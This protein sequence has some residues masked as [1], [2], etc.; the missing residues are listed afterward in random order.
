MIAHITKHELRR[1]LRDGRS[2][3]LLLA[4]FVALVASLVLSLRDYQL[5]SLQYDQNLEQARVNWEQQSEKDPHDAAHDGTYVIKPLHPLAIIDKG[6]QPFSG[7]VVHL[8][9]HE[10]KQST[11]N[12]AKDQ[13]GVFRFGELTPGFMLTYVIPLLLIFLGFNAFTEENEKQTLRLLLVQGATRRDLALG[14]WLALFV[15][16]LV[17]WLLLFTVTLVVTFSFGDQVRLSLLEIMSLSGSYLLYFVIFINLIIWVS[18]KASSSGSS[19]TSLIA[20]WIVFTLIVPKVVTNLAGS[21]YPFPTLQTF[22][23]NISRDQESGLNGHNF[24]NDAAQDFEKKVLAEYGV[25]SI[26]ELPIEYG[27]LLLAEGEKYESEVYTKHFDLLQSQYTKQ[28]SIYRWSSFLSPMLAIRFVS[29]GIS[30]TDYGFQWHFED[31]AEKYR[32][33]FNTDLNMDIAEN[34]KGVDRYTAGNDL[35]VNIQEFNYEW[36]QGNE[37]LKSHLQ[38]MAIIFLWAFFSF[39]LAVFYSRKVKVA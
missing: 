10:R 4:V 16:T 31:Q 17:L 5:T 2:R 23:E 32:V 33:E 11:L 29:M 26:E 38:E 37:I 20:I 14:K 13:S 7:K 24:W 25:D 9:A 30:R 34:A 36:Q 8:G 19:L 18:S 27:G 28:R 6:I 39:F 21:I 15:Q 35:W 3:N 12:E 22:Q 1:Y